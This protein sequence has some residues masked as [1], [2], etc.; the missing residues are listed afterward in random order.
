MS[1]GE[2][3]L[4]IEGDAL[5]CGHCGARHELQMPL[6]VWAFTALIEGWRKNHKACRPNPAVAKRDADRLAASF[7]DPHAWMAGP[8]TGLSSKTIWSV[9]MGVHCA[10]PSAPMDPSDFGRCH[11][12]LKAFPL[13]RERLAE[14]AAKHPDWS[15][16][17]EH[18]AELEAL[19]EE[20]L[21][22]GRGPKLYKR[23]QELRR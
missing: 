1:K 21:P 15:G 3:H 18:W 13:W 17:I 5:V 8:D 14:V 23:M 20:E 2:K 4:G 19:Y 12:L 7:A 6:E 16:L 11:R 22:T 9:M 10:R